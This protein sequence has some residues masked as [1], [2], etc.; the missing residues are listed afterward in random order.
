M[1]HK[2]V[3]LSVLLLARNLTTQAQQAT[4]AT[5]GLLISFNTKITI[6]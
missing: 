2:R 5:V 4:A 6:L 3:K 1:K